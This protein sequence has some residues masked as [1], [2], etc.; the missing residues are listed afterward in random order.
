MFALNNTTNTSRKKCIQ[1]KEAK[2][3]I[4]IN[5]FI[6]ILY[7]KQYVYIYISNMFM[8]L[9]YL[10]L[11]DPQENDSHHLVFYLRHSILR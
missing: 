4:L 5:T 2:K 1:D 11:K 9:N 8:I 7:G 10:S 3:K 6:Y